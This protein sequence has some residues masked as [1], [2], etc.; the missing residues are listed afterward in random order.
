MYSSWPGGASIKNLIIEYSDRLARFGYSYIERH[1]KHCGVEIIA[2]TEKEPEDAHTELDGGLTG[3][4]H[5]LF[6]P[7][8]RGQGRQKSQTEVSGTDCG[9]GAG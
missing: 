1:L 4:S 6:G 5:V 2:I 7:V 3:R 8:V 9:S